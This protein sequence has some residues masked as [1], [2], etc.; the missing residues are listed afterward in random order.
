MG[1]WFESVAEARRRARKHLPKSVYGALVAGSE[2]GLTVE[3][4]ITAFGELGGRSAGPGCRTSTSGRPWP[5]APG[6]S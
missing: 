2:Q 5:W 1:E 6:P 3:D 4:N